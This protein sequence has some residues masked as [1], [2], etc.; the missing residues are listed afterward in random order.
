MASKRQSRG[1]VGDVSVFGVQNLPET[2]AKSGGV[3]LWY[4]WGVTGPP[5]ALGTPIKQWVSPAGNGIF[6]YASPEI[7]ATLKSRAD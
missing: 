6:I 4:E 2:F 3:V 5:A 7:Q 1:S